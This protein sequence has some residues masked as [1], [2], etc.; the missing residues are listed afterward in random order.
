VKFKSSIYLL[1]SALPESQEAVD[2]IY[3]PAIYYQNMYTFT[4]LTET[5]VNTPLKWSS[6]SEKDPMIKITSVEEATYT[7]DAEINPDEPVSGFP[8]VVDI[9]VNNLKSMGKVTKGSPA[10]K[11]NYEYEND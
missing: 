2:K 11:V 5:N 4:N 10:V 1:K 6:L 9:Y 8:P 3:F 7:Y